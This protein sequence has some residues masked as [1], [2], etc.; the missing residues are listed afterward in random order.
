MTTASELTEALLNPSDAVE[1]N[2]LLEEKD[3]SSYAVE[4]L[5]VFLTRVSE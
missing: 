3:E 2:S 1:L 5:D 4:N